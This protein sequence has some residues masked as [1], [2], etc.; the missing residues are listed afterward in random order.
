MSKCGI[1][2][3]TIEDGEPHAEMEVRPEGLPVERGEFLLCGPCTEWGLRVAKH[4][5]LRRSPAPLD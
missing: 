3:E 1:C 5:D 4:T 2:G